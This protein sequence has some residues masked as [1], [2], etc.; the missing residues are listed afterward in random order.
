MNNMKN[1]KLKTLLVLC[2]AAMS[3]S[4]DSDDDNNTTPVYQP[5]SPLQG[6]LTN[7]GFNEQI[8]EVIDGSDQEYGFKFRPTVTGAIT[9]LSVKIPDVNNNLRV[10]VWDVASQTAIKTETFNITS[11]GVAV[12]KAISP[13]PLVKDKEYMITINSADYYEHSKDD[14]SNATYPLS[15]GNIQITGFASTNGLLQTFPTTASGNF[16]AGDV[17]FTFLRTL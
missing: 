11:S 7:S 1:F 8:D 15:V 2:I 5:E 12:A 13:L 9:T 4:C 10:T 3:F 17:N 14:G 6:Y 16:Y